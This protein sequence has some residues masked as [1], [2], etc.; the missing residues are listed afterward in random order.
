MFVRRLLS[1]LALAALA[2][3]FLALALLALARNLG[4][5]ELEPFGQSRQVALF[6]STTA[7]IDFAAIG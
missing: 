5:H 4:E 7:A 3:L 2:F 1:P 6:F